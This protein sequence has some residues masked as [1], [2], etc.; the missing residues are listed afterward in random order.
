MED[1]FVSIELSKKSKRYLISKGKVEYHFSP[2][3]LDPDLVGE[4][5]PRI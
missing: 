3:D 2:S 1:F 5:T 4:S